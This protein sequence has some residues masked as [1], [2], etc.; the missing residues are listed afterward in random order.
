MPVGLPVG[1]LNDALYFPYLT[2]YFYTV[3]H[4]A[5]SSTD[6]ALSTLCI[7]R[8]RWTGRDCR[9]MFHSGWIPVD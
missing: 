3:I 9:I 6:T 4:D 7:P 1:L 8:R 5:S 2:V